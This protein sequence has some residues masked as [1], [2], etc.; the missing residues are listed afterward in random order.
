MKLDKQQLEILR[1]VRMNLEECQSVT[2]ICL[3]VMDEIY[4]AKNAEL[5][6]LCNRI[7]FWR[8]FA[9]RGKWI[10][11]EHALCRAIQNELNGFSTVGCWFDDATRH[12]GLN[13]CDGDR[14][15]RRLY[16]QIRLAWLDRIIQ[17]GDVKLF[18]KMIET[19]TIA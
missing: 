6:L 9:I 13:L 8:S 12:V 1:N 2:Y 14:H 11:R 3:N 4:R 15:N 10:D 19:R 16:R 7:L 18:D 17:M 5:N